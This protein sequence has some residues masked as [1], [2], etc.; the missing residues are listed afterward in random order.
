M[1]ANIK[2]RIS[3]TDDCHTCFGRNC[4]VLS[5]CPSRPYSPKPHVYRS[6][7][8]A[9]AALW[10]LPHEMSRMR[11]D[12]NA[13]I[14]RG[15]SQFLV[16]TQPMV[17]QQI[18]LKVTEKGIYLNKSVHIMIDISLVIY[19]RCLYVPIKKNSPQKPCYTS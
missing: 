14:N 9:M 1:H 2:I 7:L 3:N 11:F 18:H 8:E 13:S 19:Y 5:P 4:V 6:P 12:R 17:Q 15:L 10:E 16:N